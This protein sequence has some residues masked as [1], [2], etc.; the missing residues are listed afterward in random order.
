MSSP[1]QPTVT[2]TGG[3]PAATRTNVGGSAPT[4]I[5]PGSEVDGSVTIFNLPTGTQTFV[6]PAL[7]SN[8]N[9]PNTPNYSHGQGQGA[10][11]SQ[12]KLALIIGSTVAGI[13]VIAIVGLLIQRGRAR[14]RTN[15]INSHQS[16]NRQKQNNQNSN[17]GVSTGAAGNMSGGED[18]RGDKSKLARSFTIRKPPSVYIED[19]Q[20]LDQTGHPHYKSASD[21]LNHPY[22]GERTPGLVEYELSDTSGQKYSP[23]SIAERKR[24]VEQQQRKVMDEYEMFNPYMDLPPP[25]PYPASVSGSAAPSYTSGP[26]SPTMGGRSPRV[27]HNPSQ[28]PTHSSFGRPMQQQFDS[29]DYRY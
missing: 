3:A 7:P 15:A 9:G 26:L 21:A 28:S 1:R 2:A 29:N 25:S 13:A 11:G 22:Y 16:R 27:H 20:D 12:T 19:D 10:N 5:I 6:Y 17:S 23:S 4:Y 24:Y 18:D 14:A 8:A